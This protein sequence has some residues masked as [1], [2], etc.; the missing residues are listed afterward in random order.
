MK[1]YNYTREL[2][3]WDSLKDAETKEALHQG[4]GAHLECV[5]G[6]MLGR[7]ENGQFI[8]LRYHSVRGV[9]DNKRVYIMSSSSLWALE[10]RWEKQ[11]R[12]VR[13]K[14]RVNVL[15][16]NGKWTTSSL[17]SA[18][19]T[20]QIC[21]RKWWNWKSRGIKEGRKVKFSAKFIWSV[22]EMAWLTRKFLLYLLCSKNVDISVYMY[23]NNF[24]IFILT[25]LNFPQCSCLLLKVKF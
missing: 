13:G 7:E 10:K 11:R 6:K 16:E 24:L 4:A 21:Q 12:N 17:V 22:P 18:A 20:G 8:D 23:G 25:R 15:A 14:L 19:F 1:G 2:V 3:A 5:T 9:K